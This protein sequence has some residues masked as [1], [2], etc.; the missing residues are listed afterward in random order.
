M[1]FSHLTAALTVELAAANYTASERVYFITVGVRLTGTAEIPLT[2]YIS[3]VNQTAVSGEDFVALQ[4]TSVVF[5][6]L[7]DSAELRVEI[8]NDE[9]VEGTE[10]FQVSIERTGIPARV[11][12]G[13]D[14][15][16]ITLEDDDCKF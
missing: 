9:R 14:T 16:N 5:S 2:F 6:P 11:V 3:T 13:R 12:I 7:S 15:A 1:L 4:R 8:L 10:M